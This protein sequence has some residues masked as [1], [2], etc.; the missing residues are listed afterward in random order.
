MHLQTQSGEP[1]LKVWLE[2]KGK[3]I[4][5]P[6]SAALAGNCHRLLLESIG[7]VLSDSAHS[8]LIWIVQEQICI[9]TIALA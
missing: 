3:R 2:N 1:E 7:D 5:E 9:L 6:S 4:C 8:G